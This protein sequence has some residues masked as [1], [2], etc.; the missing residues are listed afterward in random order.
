MHGNVSLCASST[1]PAA[2]FKPFAADTAEGVFDAF[3]AASSASTSETAES[4]SG[5]YG[6]M[7]VAGTA[8]AGADLVLTITMGWNFPFRDHFNYKPPYTN[9]VPYGN[10][11]STIYPDAADTAATMD[12]QQTLDDI[13]AWQSAL[14][15]PTQSA[16]GEQKGSDDD[17]QWTLPSWLGDVLVNSLSHTRDLMWWSACPHCH[18]SQDGRV[19]GTLDPAEGGFWRQYEA[20]DC[21]DLDSIHND[22][23]RH[24]PYIMFF[25][26]GTRSKMAVSESYTVRYDSLCVTTS[27]STW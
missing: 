19:N 1:D 11:Y 25:P 4:I 20:Y 3:A 26:N 17:T 21:P 7:S 27:G 10:H 12:L 5:L 23:E 9:F 24:I 2:T 8:K 22:G 15:P 14:L 16:K 6:G 13:N 18:V